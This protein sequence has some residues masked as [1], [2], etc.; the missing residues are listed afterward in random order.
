MLKTTYTTNRC[1]ALYDGLKRVV[2]IINNLSRFFDFGFFKLFVY[3]NITAFTV[4]R[5]R[6]NSARAPSPTLNHI[7]LYGHE[8]VIYILL[9][10]VTK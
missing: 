2:V 9:K 7:I 5:G 6:S 3:S 10:Y 1:L 8:C 4:E